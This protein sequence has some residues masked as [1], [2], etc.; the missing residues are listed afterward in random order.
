MRWLTRNHRGLVFYDSAH[1]GRLP[2]ETDAMLEDRV[3]LRWAQMDGDAVAESDDARLVA[4]WLRANIAA[5]MR[6]MM[7]RSNMDLMSG[8]DLMAEAARLWHA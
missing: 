8:A 2:G 6:T 5:R 4:A 7:R 1:V 3:M